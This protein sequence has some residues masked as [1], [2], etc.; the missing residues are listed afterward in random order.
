[1]IKI[2]GLDKLSRDLTSAQKA[3]EGLDGELGTVAFDPSDLGSIEA[4]IQEVERLVDERLGSYAS[5]RII[6]PMAEGMK[7]QYRE[8]I[9][10]RAATARLEGDQA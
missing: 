8:A 10:E 1:M 5:N 2:T 7:Q 4:A 6:G 3:L 9:L